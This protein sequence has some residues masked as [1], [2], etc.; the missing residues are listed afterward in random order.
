MGNDGVL[1]KLITCDLVIGLQRIF[2]SE[3]LN[4]RKDLINKNNSYHLL[5]VPYLSGHVLNALYILAHLI[6]IKFI[7]T[8]LFSYI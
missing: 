7:V 5:S 1:E 2:Q 8:G 6:Y 4:R 3:I